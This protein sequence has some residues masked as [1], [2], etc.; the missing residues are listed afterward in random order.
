MSRNSKQSKGGGL[1]LKR[2]EGERVT[3]NHGEMVIEV[4]E[5]KGKT[6]RLAFQG[7]RDVVVLREE[8]EPNREEDPA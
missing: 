4:V 5:I 6:V 1:V 3:I 7:P 2:R 8:E